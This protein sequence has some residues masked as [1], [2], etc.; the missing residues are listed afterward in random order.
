M[1]W[2]GLG[3]AGLGGATHSIHGCT[4]L[5]YVG[6]GILCLRACVRVR[7]RVGARGD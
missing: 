7:V 6:Y 3:W 2:A 5:Y 1:G 4:E